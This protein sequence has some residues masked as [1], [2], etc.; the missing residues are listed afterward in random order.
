MGVWIAGCLEDQTA[1]MKGDGEA[2]VTKKCVLCG[3]SV[4]L[5]VKKN[6]QVFLWELSLCFGMLLSTL[7][8]HQIE[9]STNTHTARFALEI[10]K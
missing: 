6:K 4:C 1:G 10:K 8:L 3:K 2:V 7:T 5:W 9:E